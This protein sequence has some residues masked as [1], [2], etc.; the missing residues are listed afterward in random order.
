[1][2]AWLR[3]FALTTLA[4]VFALGFL[5]LRRVP[6]PIF[7]GKYASQWC[8]ELLSS[9]YKT[10][11]EAQA[12][13]LGLGESSVPQLRVMLRRRNPPWEKHLVRAANYLPY[14]NY[15]V[16]DG[17]LSRQ[18]AAEMAAWLGPKAAPAVPE[19]I[20]ALEQD[21]TAPEA[22][23]ALLRI[24]SA[25]EDAVREALVRNG[26]MEIR[27]RT[28][29]LLREGRPLTPKSIEALVQA[30]RDAAPQVRREAA[31]S[32]ARAESNAGE[33]QRALLEL[34]D[35]PI[36]Q[37]RAGA[38]IAL[39][40]RKIAPA[41]V[42]Q[43]LRQTVND[44]APEVRLE[45]AK[46]L[47]QLGVDSSE[48]LPVLVAILETDCAWQAAYALADLRARAAP[49]IPQLI[50]ALQ[51]ERAHRPF[52]T[53][54]SSAFALGRIGA[55]AVPALSE[56]LSAPQPHIRM[57]AVLALGFIGPVADPAVPALLPL[58]RDQ[59]R[60]VRHAT[61]LTLGSIGADSEEVI[62]AL[63]DCLSAE[64]I[65]MRFAA[66]DL[67]RKLEPEGNWYASP[68]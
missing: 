43:K 2:K 58:L 33:T 57:G 6:D 13:L 18:R 41:H 4:L 51:R 12:A 22:E 21:K 60:E 53:P 24:G 31:L 28:A 47:W 15:Q 27:E 63:A 44:R 34:L 45:S 50:A 17:V 16:R 42:L 14:F 48:V 11:N 65:Y 37:V 35:D 7:E 39:G 54:P 29:R 8:D 56:I 55:A 36:P 3:I 52:R 46:A 20:A 67:L 9:D 32:L 5:L 59:D 23:R 40:D 66:A 30:T 1:M 64:D 61:A 26:S 62:T 68:E 19:L 25:A 49:A 38:A 10:R